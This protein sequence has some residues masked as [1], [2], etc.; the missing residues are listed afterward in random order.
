ML[1]FII[2]IAAY[3]EVFSIILAFSFVY[4]F[5]KN[6]KQ[7]DFLEEMIIDQ[8]DTRNRVYQMSRI[9][10]NKVQSAYIFS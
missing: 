9:Y 8:S 4:Y 10:Y 3:F 1:C 5:K 7:S 6:S 2:E